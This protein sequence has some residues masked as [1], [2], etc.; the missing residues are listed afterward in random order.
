[1]F[2]WKAAIP[3]R[4][5]PILSH[6]SLFLAIPRKTQRQNHCAPS[7]QWW[8]SLWKA[9]GWI[10]CTTLGWEFTR[11]KQRAASVTFRELSWD[12][13]GPGEATTT[14]GVC[15]SWC[16]VH[17][18]AMSIPQSCSSWPPVH[19]RILPLPEFTQPVW[20]LCWAPTPSLLIPEQPCRAQPSLPLSILLPF[21]PCRAGSTASTSP[22]S[23]QHHNTLNSCSPFQQTAQTLQ[24]YL[25]QS[26]SYRSCTQQLPQTPRQPILLQYLEKF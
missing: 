21:S 19:P 17:P 22:N 12:K 13:P 7:S 24:Q 5:A 15:L 8:N 20:M 16:P 2:G 6:L 26:Q 11:H 4:A 3:V 10:L 23:S 14:L 25:W 18:G 1:M 9:L